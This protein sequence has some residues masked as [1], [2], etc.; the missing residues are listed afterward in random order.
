MTSEELEKLNS[1]ELLNMQK[2]IT[3]ILMDRE[4][5]KM[6]TERRERDESRL[7]VK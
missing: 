4:L 7:S 2:N 6:M 5:Q 1:F 3:Y